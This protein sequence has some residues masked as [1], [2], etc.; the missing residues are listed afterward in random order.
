V[1][2]H[3]NCEH[4]HCWLLDIALKLSELEL[5]R[6]TVVAQADSSVHRTTA[7]N[8][9]FG[10]RFISLPFLSSFDLESMHRDCVLCRVTSSELASR[11]QKNTSEALRATR[12]F[13]ACL[14]HDV[15]LNY[16]PIRRHIRAST[17]G[18]MIGAMLRTNSPERT[19][20]AAARMS[21]ASRRSCS[22]GCT[23][24]RSARCAR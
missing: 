6:V 23:K 24:S 21:G 19:S 3:P 12:D 9:P 18:R 4:H 15:L 8:V 22:R 14:V 7:S 17:L 16:A 2:P 13:F 1:Q 5:T 11:H 20:S 10:I